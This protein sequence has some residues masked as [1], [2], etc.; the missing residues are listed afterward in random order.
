MSDETVGT[1]KYTK[2]KIRHGRKILIYHLIVMHL[3]T[4][5]VAL[6]PAA[7]RVLPREQKLAGAAQ[8]RR[9]QLGL[10][11]QINDGGQRV[12]NRVHSDT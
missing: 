2:T 9:V 1:S 5:E 4:Y 12:Q 11:R 8:A 10:R 6:A 7:I 3:T